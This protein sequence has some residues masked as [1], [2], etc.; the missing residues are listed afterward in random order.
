MQITGV[1][2]WNHI[3][4]QLG[5]DYQI[6]VQHAG[7]EGKR[8]YQRYTPTSSYMTIRGDCPDHYTPDHECSNAVTVRISDH[9]PTRHNDYLLY[10]GTTGPDGNEYDNG[11]E[12]DRCIAQVKTL[13]SFNAA[14]DEK[15]KAQAHQKDVREAAVRI[16]AEDWDDSVARELIDRISRDEAF[17]AFNVMTAEDLTARLTSSEKKMLAQQITLDVEARLVMEEYDDARVAARE[18]MAEISN[19]V[20]WGDDD[21]PID[22]NPGLYESEDYDSNAAT[23][24]MDILGENGN[25]Q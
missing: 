8:V 16:L 23:L 5:G 15:Y 18:R 21:D 4:K 19:L 24:L 25:E 10:A 2:A 22:N 1:E 3:L 17:A 13:V 20:V 9:D 7:Y 6:T 12:A 14:L 11:G